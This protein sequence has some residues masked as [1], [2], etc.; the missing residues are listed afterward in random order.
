MLPGRSWSYRLLRR[1][2]RKIGHYFILG[3]VAHILRLINVHPRLLL[4][5]LASRAIVFRIDWESELIV[6]KTGD[7]H[8]IV[9]FAIARTTTQTRRTPLAEPALAISRV[10]RRRRGGRSVR[11]VTLIG[12]PLI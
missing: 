11:V 2:R 10:G 6:E 1:K 12:V 4:C 5:L 8:R 9:P 3:L 7:A